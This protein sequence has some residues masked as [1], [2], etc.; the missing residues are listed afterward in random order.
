M[1]RSFPED[2]Q[3]KLFLVLLADGKRSKCK[4]QINV[5]KKVSVSSGCSSGTTVT[6]AG[7]RL[8]VP[9]TDVLLIPTCPHSGRDAASGV[10]HLDAGSNTSLVH[11]LCSFVVQRQLS[12]DAMFLV[13]VVCFLYVRS[14]RTP[15]WPLRLRFS[16]G[17]IMNDH[18]FDSIPLEFKSLLSM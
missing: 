13:H 11:F 6:P 1:E 5:P 18:R 7:R 3:T 4:G 12:V 17:T 15:T 14:A 2:L 10:S 8:L 9:I 16:V